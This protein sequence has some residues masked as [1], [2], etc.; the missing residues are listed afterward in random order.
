MRK[1]HI[2]RKKAY[3]QSQIRTLGWETKQER[4]RKKSSHQT[5]IQLLALHANHI[6][7]APALA[8]T[9]WKG[10]KGREKW[11]KMKALEKRERKM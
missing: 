10:R 1:K 9:T 6:S 4:G 11:E 2:H 8:L 7:R 3:F 5:S